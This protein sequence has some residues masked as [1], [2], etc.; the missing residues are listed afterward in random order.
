MQDDLSLRPL[1]LRV[2]HKLLEG[3]HRHEKYFEL[4]RNVENDLNFRSTVKFRVAYNSCGKDEII[5][6]SRTFYIFV[7]RMDCADW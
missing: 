7:T 6:V 5:N 4:I 1:I 3:S 2:S